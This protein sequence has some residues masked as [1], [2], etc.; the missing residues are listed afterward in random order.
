MPLS[1]RLA[2]WLVDQGHDAV[3]AAKLDLAS[4]PDTQIIAV[5]A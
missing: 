3:H 4:A 2:T 1:P 5:S